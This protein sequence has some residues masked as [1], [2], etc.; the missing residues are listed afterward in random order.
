MIDAITRYFRARLDTAAA[1]GDAHLQRRLHLATAAL[2]IEVARADDTVS[3]DEL[4]SLER[5]LSESFDLSV[6]DIEEL[7]ALAQDEA[8]RATSYFQ[9]TSLIKDHFSLDMKAKVIELLWQVAFADGR[10]D[11]YEEHFV[12]KIADLLYVPHHDFIA[13]KHRAQRGVRGR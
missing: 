11:K 8:T 4:I 3:D 1:E 13:A 12:R 10:I 2:L 6:A 7:L 5:G 9:F